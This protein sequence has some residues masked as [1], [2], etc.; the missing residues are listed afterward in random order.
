MGSTGIAGDELGQKQE[1]HFG[2][3]VL[4]SFPW[5]IVTKYY[6]ADVHFLLLPERDLVSEDFCKAVEAIIIIFDQ[7]NSSFARVQAWLPFVKEFDPEI[8]MLVCD[9]ATEAGEVTRSDIQGWC[10]E[11]SFELVELSPVEEE[12]NEDVEDDFHES[13]SYLRLRQ[14]LHAHPWPLLDLKGKYLSPSCGSPSL[15]LSP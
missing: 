1:A 6:E 2:S 14:A 11:N 4:D 10:L 13:N 8:R 5:H 7:E 9:T 3:R 15:S 12:Q